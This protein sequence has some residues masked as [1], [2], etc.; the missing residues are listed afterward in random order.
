M[1]NTPASHKLYHDPL[2]SRGNFGN[3]RRTM[4]LT[5]ISCLA[6]LT[7]SVCGI[8]HA[9]EAPAIVRK[10]SLQDC[11]RMA[12]EN[13]YNIEIGDKVSLGVSADLDLSSGGRLGLELAR[14]N[15]HQEYAVY[16]PELKMRA[17]KSWNERPGGRDP[18]TGLAGAGGYNWDQSYRMGVQGLLPSG[19][20]YEL[21][22]ETGRTM[23][24]NQPIGDPAEYDSS[25]GITLT[26]PLLKGGWMYDSSRLSLKFRKSDLKL[27]ELSFKLLVMDTLRKVSEGYYDLAAARGQVTVREKA[28]ELAGKLV[29]ENKKKVQV[30]N[31]APLDE[32]QAES[33][34]A[35]AK[36][37]L[38]Q[39]IFD[40]QSREMEL[41]SLITRDYVKVQAEAYEPT[42]SLVA[43]YQVFTLVEA[44]RTALEIRPDYLTKKENLQRDRI[45]LSFIKNGMLPQLDLSTTYRRNGLAGNTIDAYDQVADN[46]FPGWS[47]FI[48]L[49]VPLTYRQ[50]RDNLKQAKLAIQQGITDLKRTEDLVIQEVDLAIKQVK[51]T[52]EATQSTRE[53]RKFAEEALEA[54]QKKLD[55][56]KSTSFQV[57]QFQRD[58]TQAS[59][60]EIRAAAEYNKALQNLY[61]KEG[62]TLERNKVNLEIK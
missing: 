7:C 39:A 43:V 30:G 33:Q 46:R 3:V 12:L 27:A 10:L 61:F 22:T 1:K 51:S 49:T 13:N 6:L 25:A 21:F 9:A 20:T 23:D 55:N 32:R 48:T 45:S 5:R 34:A 2:T 31:L 18:L 16:D 37:D 47:G 35:T 17:G 41:K 24:S 36:A 38:T 58:L 56:G 28:L 40:A 52:Y 54:E 44:W 62:T 60:A 57:L 29:E 15:L 19:T 26:Q 8:T 53:A 59:S 11:F 4:R 14:I 42:D 50:E